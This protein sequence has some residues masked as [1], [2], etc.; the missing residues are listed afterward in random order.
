MTNK[1]KSLL[2]LAGFGAAVAGAA[3]F[4]SRYSP[5]DPRTKL[6]YNRLD[7]PGYNPPTMFF[8]SCGAACTR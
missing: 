8:R 5:K 3:W 7:K 6:W 2:A 4:G 1:S